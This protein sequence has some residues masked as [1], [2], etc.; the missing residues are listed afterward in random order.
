MSQGLGGVSAQAVLLSHLHLF[1]GKRAFEWLQRGSTSSS[2]A[3]GLIAWH[4]TA[5]P[6][7]SAPSLLSV[8]L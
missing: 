4:D 2:L 1:P 3:H 5:R 7:S 8:G 6:P